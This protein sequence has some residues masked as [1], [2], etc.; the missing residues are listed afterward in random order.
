MKRS[1]LWFLVFFA[2]VVASGASL[3]LIVPTAFD[4]EVSIHPWIPGVLGALFA[5]SAFVAW[6]VRPEW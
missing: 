3:I 2:V 5:A 6:K 1:V 4:P